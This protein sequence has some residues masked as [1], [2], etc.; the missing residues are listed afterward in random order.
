MLKTNLESMFHWEN[1][2]KLRKWMGSN[3]LNILVRGN[4]TVL[5]KNNTKRMQV[6]Q[7]RQNRQNSACA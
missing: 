2:G 1:K 6:N 7:P 5:T 4:T 3:L